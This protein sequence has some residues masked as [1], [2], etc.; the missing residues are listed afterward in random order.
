MKLPHPPDVIPTLST[1]TIKLPNSTLIT[2]TEKGYI[3]LHSSLNEAATQVKIIPQLT[4][5]SFLSIGQL[6]DNN[7]LAIFHKKYLTIFKNNKVILQG[8]RNISDGLWDIQFDKINQIISWPTFITVHCTAQ[9]LLPYVKL[10]EMIILSHGQQL[11]VF[12]FFFF[13]IFTTYDPYDQ[14]NGHRLRI[15]GSRTKKLSILKIKPPDIPDKFPRSESTRLNSSH[16]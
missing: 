14:Y 12:F 6:C 3:P 2:A 11:K 5:S 7:C 8:I 4:N 16:P 13:I 9:L 1:T 10:S 15:Y